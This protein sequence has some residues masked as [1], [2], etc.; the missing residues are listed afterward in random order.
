MT[1][2][3]IIK[4]SSEVLLLMGSLVLLACEAQEFKVSPGKVDAHQVNT[5]ESPAQLV[6]PSVLQIPNYFV[7]GGSVVKGDVLILSAK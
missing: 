5:D 1:W 6:G 4:R 3:L 2:D 7:R